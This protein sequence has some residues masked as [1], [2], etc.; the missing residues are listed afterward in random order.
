MAALISL[1]FILPVG[2]VGYKVWN[3]ELP[4]RMWG[5]WF[6]VLFLWMTYIV[7]VGMLEGPPPKSPFQATAA[8]PLE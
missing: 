4:S 7:V 5:A 2:Y 3:E 6:L 8:R 1:G